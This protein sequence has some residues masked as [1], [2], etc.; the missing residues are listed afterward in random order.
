MKK[1]DAERTAA[2]VIDAP[3]LDI[4]ECLITE[5]EEW[6]IA[7]HIL[8]YRMAHADQQQADDPAIQYWQR[9]CNCDGG[10]LL[11]FARTP[12]GVLHVMLA[13]AHSHG[14]AAYITLQ[15]II[16]P[17]HRMT[18]K[19]FSL[20]AIARELNRK[21]SESMPEGSVIAAQLIALD[22]REGTV[23]AW[24]GGMPPAVMLDAQAHPA[25][26]FSL[27]H[28]P[29]GAQ[30]NGAFDER[31]ESH[32]FTPGDQLIMVSEG[33]L[34]CSGSTGKRFG[35][36]GLAEA[37]VGLP[38]E[39]RR[40]GAVAALGRHLGEV[41]P[42]DDMTLVLIDCEQTA[43]LP[44]SPRAMPAPSHHP[45]SWGVELRLGAKELGLVDVVPMLLNVVTQFSSARDQAGVLFVIL[46]ELFN[47]A[48]DHGVLRLDSRI[49]HSPEGMET[50]LMLREERLAALR[51]GEIRL[52]VNQVVDANGAHLEIRC[53]DSGPGFDVQAMLNHA[54]TV[55]TAETVGVLPFGRGLIL[56]QGLAQSVNFGDRGNDVR[57][58][59]QV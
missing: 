28:L 58:S 55:S 56:L 9:H 13:D 12:N 35:E 1:F 2:A 34:D 21:V 39:Q 11:A 53:Q 41:L 49:K 32:A 31:I 52:A 47:N 42:Q 57:V 38:C 23:S 30:R 8:E 48:L 20:T 25:Y 3:A 22:Q 46:S 26:E 24:N 45:G 33:L 40:Q 14:M 44:A 27:C 18:E 43:A 6:R 59:L 50:W 10:D 29:L 16:L 36:Q 54:V 7:R 4:R 37:I 15:P 17:F 51:E 5:A 19:G